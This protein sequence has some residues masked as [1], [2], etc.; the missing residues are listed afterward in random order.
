VRPIGRQALGAQLHSGATR[1]QRTCSF[2]E[3]V[4]KGREA[5]T[6]TGHPKDPTVSFLKIEEVPNGA[7]ATADRQQVAALLDLPE[8]AVP[9][10]RL[11]WCH[12]R[13][14]PQGKLWGCCPKVP[15]DLEAKVGHHVDT[16]NPSKKEAVLGSVPLKTT[17]C[18]G[19]LGL[20]RPPREHHV[21]R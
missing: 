11:T 19:A 18:N 10:V 21:C 8:D 16:Q 12:V 3:V 1:L 4:K 6:K 9:P 13:Q 15:S 7:R 20:E 17:D 2:P 14:G 5:T